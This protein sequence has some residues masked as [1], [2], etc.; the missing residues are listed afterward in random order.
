MASVTP[1]DVEKLTKPT[2]GKWLQ[3]LIINLINLTY[4]QFILG[5]LCPLS[6]NSYGI[7]FQQFTI[8]DYETK[9]II[10]EV[11]RN[12]PPQDM[13]LDF[14]T[15]GEDMYRKIKYEFSEDVLRLPQIETS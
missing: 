13:S 15:P 4:S 6:A 11:G 8:S 12:T 5:F 9:K 14:S 2:D 10:F 7:D 3:K 1:Q